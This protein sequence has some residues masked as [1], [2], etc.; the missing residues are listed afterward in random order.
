MLDI[1]REWTPNRRLP[2]SSALSASS[3]RR[4]SDPSA[5][6][7]SQLRIEDMT[8]CSRRARGFAFGNSMASVAELSLQY[9]D[10]GEERAEPP[11]GIRISFRPSRVLQ[12]G[13]ASLRGSRSRFKCFLM[14]HPESVIS[15][16]SSRA[17]A[18]GEPIAERLGHGVVVAHA[19]NVPLIGESRNKD[20]RLE[21]R[22]QARLARIDPQLTIE[23][24]PFA[25][26]RASPK[27]RSPT[28]SPALRP[29]NP[30]RKNTTRSA[31]ASNPRRG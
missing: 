30:R 28:Y 3:Q 12:F 9:S 27:L 31:I 25:H 1:R 29:K 5:G 21:A 15:R 7:T 24:P 22:T 6:A 23:G 2:K 16:N 10:Y 19:R 8:K 17:P 14:L 20:D 18:N 4:T 13:F 11:L 26:K